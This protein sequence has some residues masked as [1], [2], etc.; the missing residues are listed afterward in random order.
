MKRINLTNLIKI[1]FVFLLSI[2]LFACTSTS[3]ENITDENTTEENTT[4]DKTVESTTSDAADFFVGNYTIDQGQGGGTY[5]ITKTSANAISIEISCQDD[6]VFTLN[7]NVAGKGLTFPEQDVTIKDK[8]GKL[9][10]STLSDYDGSEG[11]TLDLNYSFKVGDAEAS[12]NT[13]QGAKNK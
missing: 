10:G 7:A 3:T 2:S 5:K 6:G 13:L 1:S 4:G 9:S 11:S 12:V 8:A